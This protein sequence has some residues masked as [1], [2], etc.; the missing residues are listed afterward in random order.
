MALA[1]IAFLTDEDEYAV[2]GTAN[3]DEIIAEHQK[4]SSQLLVIR[5][6]LSHACSR[7][8]IILHL[9]ISRRKT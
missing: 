4:Q 1:D 8:L 3:V 2:Y 7:H 9:F 5:Q 6:A